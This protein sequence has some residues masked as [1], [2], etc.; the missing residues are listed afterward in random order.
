MVS[1]PT[2]LPGDVGPRFECGSSA[3][4]SGNPHYRGDLQDT[5]TEELRQ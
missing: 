1:P 2:R 5:A 3:R 4:P